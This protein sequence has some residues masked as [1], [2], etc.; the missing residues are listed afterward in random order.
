[1]SVLL[2]DVHSKQR[3]Y[4]SIF[5]PYSTFLCCCKKCLR[6]PVVPLVAVKRLLISTWFLHSSGAIPTQPYYSTGCIAVSGWVH[7]VV[8]QHAVM[9]ACCSEPHVLISE[10]SDDLRAMSVCR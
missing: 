8:P 6:E 10:S 3:A 4:T 7:C 5:M 2:M 1:M 9:I